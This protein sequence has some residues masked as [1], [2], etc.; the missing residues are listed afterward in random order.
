MEDVVPHGFYCTDWRV[1]Q[2]NGE[3]TAWPKKGS[4][5]D[6]LN[7][8]M[9]YGECL[10]RYVWLEMDIGNSQMTVLVKIRIACKFTTP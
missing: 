2:S 5:F 4:V 1:I 8:Y 3:G 10:C 9:D 7:V 6:F